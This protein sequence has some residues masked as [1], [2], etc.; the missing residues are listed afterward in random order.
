METEDKTMS[1]LAIFICLAE[2]ENLLK[3]NAKWSVRIRVLFGIL[4]ALF[5]IF[6]Q[7]PF[8]MTVAGILTLQAIVLKV[9]IYKEDKILDALEKFC[10]KNNVD[11]VEE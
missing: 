2:Y 8:L 11:F 9:F 10:N 3:K 6:M 7:F 4:Y 1:E 5:G